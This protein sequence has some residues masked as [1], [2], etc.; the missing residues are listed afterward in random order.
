MRTLNQYHQF[1]SACC[2]PAFV[3][4]GF[5]VHVLSAQ[6]LRITLVYSWENGS[7]NRKVTSS[8]A[9]RWQAVK[10][11]S[12]SRSTCTQAC[13][14]FLLPCFSANCPEWMESGSLVVVQSLSLVWLFAAPWA[15]AHQASLSFTISWSLLKFMSTELVLS[16]LSTVT[17][18]SW[19]ALHGMAHSF[20][21]LHKPLYHDEAVISY[22][23]FMMSYGRNQHDIVKQL[24]SN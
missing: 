15:A 14:L 20:I 4:E 22:D 5:Q 21:E 6:Q 1:W 9:G 23:W 2:W 10:S 11:W 17:R 24:S 3:T 16:E 12:R 8:V 19:V 18:P 7:A 13:V